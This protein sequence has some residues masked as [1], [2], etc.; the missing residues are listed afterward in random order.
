MNWRDEK[1]TLRHDYAAGRDEHFVQE[2]TP[3]RNFVPLCTKVGTESLC[4]HRF[5]LVLG[6]ASALN[7]NSINKFMFR[8][9]I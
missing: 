1:R 2:L 7:G 3:Y 4:T 6:H 8:N 5:L 9:G